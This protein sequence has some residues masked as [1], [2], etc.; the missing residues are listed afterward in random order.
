MF[1]SIN[2]HYHT[3][4][5]KK[6][7]SFLLVL[8]LSVTF[9]LS[10]GATASTTVTSTKLVAS[11]IVTSF[12]DVSSNISLKQSVEKLALLGIINGGT[13]GLFHPDSLVTREQFAK[14]IV[15]AANLATAANIATNSTTF[16]DVP[17]ARW[18]SGYIRTAASNGMLNGYPDGLFHPTSK[19]TYAQAMTIMIRMLGYEESD[20][21]GTWPQNYITKAASIQLT[22]GLSYNANDE[23]TRADC[24]VLIERLFDMNVKQTAGLNGNTQTTM[25]YNESTGIYQTVVIL[26]D[27]SIDSSLDTD[28]IVTDKGNF[29]NS[30][31]STLAIGHD[32]MLKFDGS[33][34]TKVYSPTSYVTTGTVSAV[35]DGTLYYK[36]GLGTTPLVLTSNMSF[37]NNSGPINYGTLFT[38]ILSGET[39]TLAYN[40]QTTALNYIMFSKPM[41]S[42]EGTYQEL[43]ILDTAL[44]SK[45]LANN[46]VLTDKGLFTIAYGVVVPTPGTRIGGII[47]GTS[48]TQITGQINQT[49]NTTLLQTAGTTAVMVKDGTI[50]TGQLPL[51]AKW[52]YHGVVLPSS[53]LTASITRNSSI[54]FGMNPSGEGEEYALLYD[55]I[56]SD[57]QLADS[58][59]LY[60]M[61]LGSIDLHDVTLTRDGDIIAIYE[62]MYHDTAYNVTDIWGGNRY[63]SLYSNNI[64]GTIE[65][66]TPNRFSPGSITIS[67]YN[68]TTKKMESKSYGFSTEFSVTD[69]YNDKFQVGESAILILGRDGKIIRML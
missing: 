62:I 21:A 32:Y 34:I 45:D 11:K 52:Y 9:S 38:D 39:V 36:L 35:S 30:S 63:V 5:I 57:P 58:Q 60:D 22:N 28:E 69:L 67:I 3:G 25:T 44:T 55:P 17:S 7:I 13:D 40:S 12:P 29:T 42:V 14:M 50:V 43:L 68:D 27:S 10:V 4:I 66:Y 16:A 48:I 37:Y 15:S 24:V 59:E 31:G 33:N 20:L 46:K 51:S 18:S 49:S 1:K 41:A 19:I 8:S 2:H 26:S 54:V 47:N 56:Y 53:N 65:S 6:A 23:L 61:T 64:A